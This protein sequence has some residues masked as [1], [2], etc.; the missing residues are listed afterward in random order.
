MGVA[1]A[2]LGDLLEAALPD[3]LPELAG[4]RRR[5]LET[6][7][8]LGDGPD[9]PVDG[10]TLAVAVRN[11]LQLL[12]E[13]GPILLAIDD[14]QWL[15]ASSANALAFALR[16]LPD[17][18]IRL[19]LTHR[20][21]SA[22][23][24]TE[25]ERALDDR[26]VERLRVGPLSP[27]ALHAILRDRL[28]CVFARPTLL[29]LHEA[30][31]GNAFFALELARALPTDIDHTQPL[32]VPE[33]LEALVRAR[34]DALPD[35]T[36]ATLLLACAHGR[37]QPAHLDGD[38]LEPAFAGGVIE[39]AEGVIRF[40]HPLL[41]SVL[42]QGASPEARR[43]AHARLAALADDQLAR[44]RHR[45]LA[46]S[47]PDAAIA[48]EL[49]EAGAGRDR[50]RC[51]DRRGGAVRAR[52]PRDAAAATEAGSDARSSP[53][54]HTWRPERAHDLARSRPSSWRRPPSGPERAEALML[55]ASSSPPTARSR[56]SRT[57]CVRRPGIRRCRPR[58]TSSWPRTDE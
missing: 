8:L 25:L 47:G 42:Y 13:R 7:L 57:R 17:H 53:P 2:A 56:C 37:I 26:N 10:R 6:A 20:T 22:N 39:V 33:T 35:A 19:L 28:D 15:D 1:H 50:P 43:S 5:A 4:P 16:R 52:C 34:L 14:V 21:T 3:V 55:L 45:A 41:A 12:A 27:G 46:S 49:E 40:T 38:A 54:T 11:V 48:A 51:A 31:G 32:P 44:A 30:S 18:R 23:P 9:E 58:F 29:R 24:L 36:R